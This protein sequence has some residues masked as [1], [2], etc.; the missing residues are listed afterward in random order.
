M[1][2]EYDPTLQSPSERR[3]LLSQGVLR[4]RSLRLPTT[5]LYLGGVRSAPIFDATLLPGENIQAAIDG[6]AKRILLLNGTHKLATDLL[7]NQVGV[8]LIG[9]TQAG[10]IID[11]D[12]L[13]V[14]IDLVGTDGYRLLA[15]MTMTNAPAPGF[16]GQVVEMIASG[17]VVRDVT[18]DSTT[19]IGIHVTIGNTDTATIENCTFLSAPVASIGQIHLNHK[20]QCAV[21]NCVFG[22]SGAG[23]CIQV[24]ETAGGAQSPVARDTISG[25]IA[26]SDCVQGWLSQ[27]TG[28]VHNLVVSG[29]HV[30]M[31]GASTPP[32]IY[33]DTAA[34]AMIS[35]N[36]LTSWP[37]GGV[38]S[39]GE[40]VY[41]GAGDLVFTSNFLDGADLRD[42]GITVATSNM[43]IG[44]NFIK[45]CA[46]DGIN[47]NGNFD[48]TIIQG[49]RISGSGA[50]GV[51]IASSNADGTII[52]GNNLKDNSSGGINNS[53]TGT[54][55]GLNVTV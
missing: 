2:P 39:S 35:G 18:F 34:Q 54:R 51:N 8:E 10:C 45:G 28:N 52:S 3:S 30:L 4:L 24:A 25:C 19:E 31:Q 15:N 7:M 17:G 32:C 37:E 48:N 36:Q 33:L 16:G 44:G 53:G 11:F 1:P 9:Q 41:V 22:G 47:I 21:R 46:A 50:F 29:N 27:R 13:Y 23:A 26:R 20:G 42:N 43:E 12:G 38:S 6:G 40:L 14:T 49:N 55:L 5:G